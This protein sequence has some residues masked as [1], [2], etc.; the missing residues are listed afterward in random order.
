MVTIGPKIVGT[1]LKDWVTTWIH[2]LILMSTGWK[3]EDVLNAT[4][5][6]LAALYK[7]WKR[8]ISWGFNPLICPKV[9]AFYVEDA[10]KSGR[11][12]IPIE[13]QQEVL[14]KI[15]LDWY[16]QEKSSHYITSKVQI[17]QRSV[18]WILKKNEY[19][20]VKPTWKS[21]LS[22]EMKAARLAFAIKY[23]DWTIEVWKRVIWIDE[24]N[25]VLGQR[26]GNYRVW[27]TVL[28][29]L[30][31]ITFTI[32]ERHPK[33]T[34]FLFWRCFSWDYKGLC[35]CWRLETKK[36]QE[37]A[38]TKIA[39]MNAEKEPKVRLEWDGNWKLELNI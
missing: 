29:K 4:D 15:N 28:E 32:Q 27:R 36:E 1:K 17:S 13:K 22:P 7:I 30:E 6:S 33:D 16:R 20:K 2:A 23:K 26:R 34:E 12:S 21:N 5:F 35:H 18:R 9:M 25:V 14:N 11:P 24:T 10:L 19:K 8:A 3:I 37:E 31:H 39:W 38:I